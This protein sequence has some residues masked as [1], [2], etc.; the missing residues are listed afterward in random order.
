MANNKLLELQT[1][2]VR[3]H[4]V[5]INFENPAWAHFPEQRLVIEP[6]KTQGRKVSRSRVRS[7]FNKGFFQTFF[8]SN[9]FFD[10]NN[11]NNNILFEKEFLSL[12]NRSRAYDLPHTSQDVTPLNYRRGE[13]GIPLYV[14]SNVTN[15]TPL[16]MWFPPLCAFSIARYY[17][18]LRICFLF[19]PES[20]PLFSCLLKLP[21]LLLP[22]S[23]LPPPMNT[24]S[25]TKT[26]L[27]IFLCLTFPTSA[28]CT[29]NLSALPRSKRLNV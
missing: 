5:K 27:G 7:Y 14:V 16:P 6:T 19:L 20:R 24:L 28:V 12:P 10:N 23:P 9:C 4:F 21:A 26:P 1:K 2:C 8:E 3:S 15:F 17:A 25:R 29:T 18:T 22:S 11:N 13:I